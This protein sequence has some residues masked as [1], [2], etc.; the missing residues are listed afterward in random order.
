MEWFKPTNP[1]LYNHNKAFEE[2]KVVT[3]KV[4]VK[5][6]KVGDILYVY[7]T[8]PDKRI[9]HKCIVEKVH[10]PKEEEIDDNKYVLSSKFDNTYEEGK[11]YVNLRLLQKLDQEGLQLKD[12]LEHDLR[13]KQSMHRITQNL[14]N[15]LK[16]IGRKIIFIGNIVGGTDQLNQ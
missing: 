3:W 8:A 14:S 7:S 11:N 15:Y 16:Q 4:E 10:V 12:L 6:I 5:E 1:K 9:T 13:N 2:L